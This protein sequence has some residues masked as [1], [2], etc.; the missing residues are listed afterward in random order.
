[1]FERQSGKKLKRMRSDLGTE[2]MKEL[3]DDFCTK[4]SVIHETTVP[5]MPEQNA[6]VERAIAVAFEMV[7]CMLHSAGMDLCYWGGAFLY[8]VYIRSCSPTYA[9]SGIVPLEAWTGKKPDVSHL[10]IFGSVTYANIPK[11]LRGGKLEV[12]SMKCRLPDWW[13]DETKGYRLEDIETG[14]LI[15]SRDVRFVENESPG[16]LV[17]VETQGAVPMKGQLDELVPK[18]TMTNVIPPSPSPM[19]ESTEAEL[20]T[21]IPVP[22]PAAEPPP[23]PVKTSKWANLPP[24]DHPIRSRNPVKRY[25]VI[26]TPDDTDFTTGSEGQHQAFVTF[27][28]KPRTY[29]EASNGPH[30]KE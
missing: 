30:S 28:N 24:R 16:D 9:L 27:E 15:T 21:E 4:N 17:V 20:P 3:I 25:G 2:F 11:K 1:M 19:P 12:T 7:R 29:K 23:N 22:A 8:A 26:A 5:Y 13:A 10:R 14:K 18:E 6:I